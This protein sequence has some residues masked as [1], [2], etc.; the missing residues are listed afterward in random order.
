[1][2]RMTEPYTP[3][4]RVGH[5]VR[6]AL[7]EH[8]VAQVEIA[9]LLGLTHASIGRRVAGHVSFRADELIRIAEHLGVEPERFF[10]P[11][12]EPR[13]RDEPVRGAA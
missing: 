13:A 12:P 11:V 7:V 5:Q 9:E 1:M 3:A 10:R 8:H 6:V 2:C 4:Q